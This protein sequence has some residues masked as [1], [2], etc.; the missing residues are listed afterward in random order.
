MILEILKDKWKE[1]EDNSC[2]KFCPKLFRFFSK[3]KVAKY[4]KPY[5]PAED[6]PQ[7]SAENSGPNDGNGGLRLST[8]LC[9]SSCWPS[10]GANLSWNLKL[11]KKSFRFKKNFQKE[12]FVKI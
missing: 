1:K 2:Q 10:D 8:I 5:L 11:T 4:R 9:H 12:F 6:R 3:I 7:A